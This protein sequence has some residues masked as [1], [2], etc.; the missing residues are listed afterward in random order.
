[1]TGWST[2]KEVDRT[3]FT[4][5]LSRFQGTKPGCLNPAQGSRQSTRIPRGVK[6]TL[7]LFFGPL[8]ARGP[9]PVRGARST[10]GEV[11]RA[12]RRFSFRERRGDRHRQREAAYRP[13][14]QRPSTRF[15]SSWRLGPP[16]PARKGKHRPKCP[17]SHGHDP[18]PGPEAPVA[19]P[20]PVTGSAGPVSTICAI[21]AIAGADPGTSPPPRGPIYPSARTRATSGRARRRRSARTIASRSLKAVSR[22]SLTTTKS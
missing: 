5:S 11:L 10:S 15:F 12:A 19:P 14:P 4:G 20:A 22:S 1:M 8:G 21:P 18:R 3:H 17:E 13:G 7:A 2:S 9:G 16:G 6:P